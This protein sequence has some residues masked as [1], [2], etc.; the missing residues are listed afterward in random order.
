MSD[1]PLTPAQ[2]EILEFERATWKYPGYRDAV[3]LE[4][5]GHSP[6]RHAQILHH[7]IDLPAA[8]VYDPTLVSRLQAIRSKRRAQRT[9][10]AW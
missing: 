3:I 1:Q 7:V 10:G 6:I 4:R 5:F 2:M 9:R 8:A